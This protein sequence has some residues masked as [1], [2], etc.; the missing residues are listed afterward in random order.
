MTLSRRLLRIYGVSKNKLMSQIH[1]T[2]A[3]NTCSE[4][5]PTT[6]KQNFLIKNHSWQKINKD[7]IV[8][9]KHLRQETKKVHGVYIAKPWK[10]TSGKHIRGY[11]VSINFLF[12][13]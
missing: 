2:T 10:I 11:S 3:P 5:E 13:R 6:E 9:N 7:I 1:E 4:T 8:E 12:Y